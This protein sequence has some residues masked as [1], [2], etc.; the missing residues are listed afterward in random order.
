MGC[1][2][3]ARRELPWLERRQ[4]SDDSQWDQ[5]MV[6]D[7]CKPNLQAHPGRPIRRMQE[8]PAQK[9][10]Q[11]KPGVYVFDLGQ[12]M[13]GWVRLHAPARPARR[14]SC[15]M[16]RCSIRTARFTRPICVLPKRP[17]LIFWPAARHVITNPLL[18]FMVF[19]TSK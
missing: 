3:D 1:V 5:V 10:T 2:Y 9:I 8:L 16:R 15:G 17:T 18:H 4:V 11:P 13:V 6:D 7:R 14:S 12:N 19:A